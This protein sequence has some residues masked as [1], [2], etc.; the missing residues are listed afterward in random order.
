MPDSWKYLLV[1]K[2]KKEREKQLKISDQDPLLWKEY[3]DKNK[4]M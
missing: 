3:T 2:K 4:K 1:P